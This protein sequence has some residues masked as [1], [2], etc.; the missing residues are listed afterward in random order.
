MVSCPAVMACL[1][2]VAAMSFSARVHGRGEFEALAVHAVAAG[3]GFA[4]AG[5]P[6]IEEP[7]PGD[8][9]E[10]L[11]LKT[12]QG[13][14][15]RGRRIPLVQHEQR[16]GPPRLPLP[17]VQSS[18]QVTDLARGLWARWMQHAIPRIRSAVLATRPLQPIRQPDRAPAATA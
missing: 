8:A 3:P 4:G 13:V 10:H 9:D 15:E 16:R 12:A 6:V 14:R 17:P 1:A 18:S 5:S 2:Q 11:D 7:V